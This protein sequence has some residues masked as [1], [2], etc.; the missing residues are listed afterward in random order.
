M[1]AIENSYQNAKFEARHDQD[2]SAHPQNRNN[3]E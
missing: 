3:K 2:D 1:V